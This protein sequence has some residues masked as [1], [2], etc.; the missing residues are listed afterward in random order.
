M[1]LIEPPLSACKV[2]PV[3]CCAGRECTY[4]KAVHGDRYGHVQLVESSPDPP[5][6]M[7]NKLYSGV[8]VQP[9]AE[10]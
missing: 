2:E 4:Y 8:R 5:L 6:S 9:A 3:Q 1:C 7:Q 10:V